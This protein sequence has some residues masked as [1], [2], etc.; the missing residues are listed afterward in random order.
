MKNI[1]YILAFLLSFSTF[2]QQV[3]GNTPKFPEKL[4]QTRASFSGWVNNTT[5]PVYQVENDEDEFDANT[6]IIRVADQDN[7]NFNSDESITLD[8]TSI[9]TFQKANG[10]TYLRLGQNSA[11][12]RWIDCADYSVVP[13]TY[14]QGEGR[15]LSRVVA[16]RAYWYYANGILYATER[17]MGTLT[18][19]TT[20]TNLIDFR[21]PIGTTGLANVYTN[22]Q[23]SSAH[24]NFSNDDIAAM[25]GTTNG[26]DVWLCVVDLI[27][28]F[29]NPND[30]GTYVLHEMELTWL[31]WANNY[32]VA[33]GLRWIK[34]NYDAT[35]L[36]VGYFTDETQPT[37]GTNNRGIWSYPIGNVTVAAGIQ[38]TSQRNHSTTAINED[39]DSVLITNDFGWRGYQD[40]TGTVW[41]ANATT[42]ANTRYPYSVSEIR[43][44][45][46][47]VTGLYWEDAV[48][49]RWGYASANNNELLGYCSFSFSGS[50][51]QAASGDAGLI[52]GLM[53][54]DGG[55]HATL[56]GENGAVFI[57]YGRIY[58]SQ[59]SGGAADELPHGNASPDGSFMVWRADYSSAGMN[60]VNITTAT[61]SKIFKKRRTF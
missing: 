61:L 35:R 13:F 23:F 58:N 46:G 10:T 24:F 36:V 45:D 20:Q 39:G 18:G 34:V 12:W 16:G 21:D 11:T 29:N 30:G 48:A 22:M 53:P 52:G 28:L 33:E 59:A 27:G 49:S 15:I 5:E 3:A 43:I 57:P 60:P 2:S 42:N 37:S 9:P 38:L 19:G 51:A 40:A 8:H 47:V 32:D 31:D 1:I 26:T 17:N 44:S 41:A 6:Q 54:L 56:G 4:P 25:I 55:D 14:S 7:V 50:I